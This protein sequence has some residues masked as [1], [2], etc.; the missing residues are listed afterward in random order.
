M[1]SASPLADPVATTPTGHRRWQHGLSSTACS[2]PSIHIDLGLWATP[3]SSRQ[4]HLH[5]HHV[6]AGHRR[7]FSATNP[8]PWSESHTE[9]QW[10]Q[11]TRQLLWL[12]F[13]GP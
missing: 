6:V 9:K 3:R 5:L 8:L 1:L 2:C 10:H 13:G 11:L 7:C 12:L 4:G